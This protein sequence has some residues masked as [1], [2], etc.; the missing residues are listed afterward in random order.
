MLCASAMHVQRQQIFK[1]VYVYDWDVQLRFVDNFLPLPCSLN[2]WEERLTT[3]FLILPDLIVDSWYVPVSKKCLTSA[4]SANSTSPLNRI[5]NIQIK[6][7]KTSKR[8]LIFCYRNV[9]F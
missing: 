4:V 6:K 5:N 8:N 7:H 2:F 9:S 3:R 1:Y